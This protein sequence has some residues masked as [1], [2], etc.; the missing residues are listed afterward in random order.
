MKRFSITILAIVATA[1]TASVQ[2]ANLAYDDASNY[3]GVWTNGSNGGY[4]FGNWVLGTTGSAGMFVGDSTLNAGGSSGGINTSGV[5][6]GMWA[7]SGGLSEAIRPFTGGP[8][9]LGQSV[10]VDFD[11]GWIDTGSTVGL[12]LQTSGGSN[13]IELYFIG[14]NSTYTINN[15]SPIDAGV[16]FTGDGLRLTFTL[17]GPNAMILT[18][19]SLNG[20]NGGTNSVFTGLSL[21]GGTGLDIERIRFFNASAGPGSNYDAFYNRLE[22]IPEPSTVFLVGLGLAGAWYLRRRKA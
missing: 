16:G 10:V 11:N 14:G 12:A 4:G 5:A 2:G 22:I 13:R 19:G 7:N 17:T 9:T 1:L 6:W 8:L 20:S 3:S 21:N 15:G 18:V